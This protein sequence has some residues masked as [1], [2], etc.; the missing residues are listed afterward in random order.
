MLFAQLRCGLL[1]KRRKLQA[2]DVLVNISGA[3]A[4]DL[5]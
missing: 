5:R 1:G 4:L 2:V 3:L